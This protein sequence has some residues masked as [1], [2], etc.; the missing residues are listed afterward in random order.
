MELVCYSSATN[1]LLL[2]LFFNFHSHSNMKCI[3]SNLVWDLI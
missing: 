1:L 3:C 2:M